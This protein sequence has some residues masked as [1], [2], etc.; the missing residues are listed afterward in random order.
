M[1][2]AE[3]TKERPPHYSKY[4]GTFDLSFWWWYLLLLG[5][6]TAKRYNTVQ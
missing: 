2:L 3:R 4:I 5:K 1:L 6:G